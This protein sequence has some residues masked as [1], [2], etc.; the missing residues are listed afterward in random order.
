MGE[1]NAS[2]R[3][4][5]HGCTHLCWQGSKDGTPTHSAAPLTVSSCFFPIHSKPRPG[6]SPCQDQLLPLSP[7]PWRPGELVLVPHNEI[8]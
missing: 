1:Q 8:L 7:V 5:V 3:D 2:Y 4:G 6:P